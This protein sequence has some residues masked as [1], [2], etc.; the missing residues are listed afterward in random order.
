M[1]ADGPGG[2]R[3]PDPPDGGKGPMYI[4]WS[5]GGSKLAFGGG[6]EPP[7]TMTVLDLAT[8]TITTAEFA[9][10]YPGEIKWSPDGATLAVST[11]DGE[12][13]HHETWIIDPRT[14]AGTHLMDG[15]IIVWSPDSR[16][17]AVHGEDIPGIAIVEAASGARMQLTA[18]RADAPLLWT[19]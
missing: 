15:C 17:L 13:T 6:F 9:S 18:A 5:P 4:A 12:R 7:Y 14:G 1:G 10:G 2:V 16:F 11:Y 19:R 8:G 3:V